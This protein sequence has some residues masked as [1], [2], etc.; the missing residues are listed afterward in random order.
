MPRPTKR[1]GSARSSAT[2]IARDA[3]IDDLPRDA[4]DA[5]EDGRDHILLDDDNRQITQPRQEEGT[6]PRSSCF[7][8]TPDPCAHSDTH[9]SLD[10]ELV[11]QEREILGVDYARDYDDDDDDDDDDEQEYGEEEEEEELYNLPEP[12]SK[13]RKKMAKPTVDVSEDSDDYDDDD[14][15]VDEDDE[16]GGKAAP[17]VD[18]LGWGSNKYAYYNANNLDNIDS[19]SEI[20]EEQARELELKEVKRLQRKSRS[21]MDD[22]DFGL[23][24]DEVEGGLGK[25]LKDAGREQRRRE[26]DG[27]DEQSAPASAAVSTE[28]EPLP[29]DEQG[30]QA[31][32]AKLQ[33]TSPETIALAGEYA[34]MLEELTKVNAG[35][36]K[37]AVEKPGHP[38][39]EVLHLHRQTLITYLTTITFYFHLRASPEYAADPAKLSSHPVLAR[40]TKLKQALSVME[41]L[42]LSF[43]GDDIDR[44]AGSDEEIDDEDGMGD[45][46][47]FQDASGD[48]DDLGSLE[49]DE[50]AA[51][52]AD[53]KENAVPAKSS[54]KNTAGGKANGVLQPVPEPGASEKKKKKS[55]KPAATQDADESGSQKRARGKKQKKA[56]PAP[57]AAGLADLDDE[58]MPE[59]K[60][61]SSKKGKAPA[62]NPFAMDQY[63]GDLEAS[64]F[65]E[66]TQLDTTDSAEKQAKK[67]SLQFHA[68]AVETKNNQRKAAR[69]RLT[70]DA[71]I[72]YRDRERSRMAVEQAK[73][74][75]RRALLGQEQDTSLDE[76]GWGESDTRDW[77]DVM[78]VDGDMDADGSGA[79]DEDGDY[80]DLIASGKRKAKKAKKDEYE[81]MRD[82][83]RFV[84]EDLLEEGQ[85][86]GINRAIEK[87]KGLAPHRPK[88]ARNPRVKKRLKYEQA[89]KRLSSRQAVFKGGQASL[90][91]GYGGESSG[92]STNLVRSRKLG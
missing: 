66:P 41:D 56:E 75:K 88:T 60:L 82:E 67:R 23:G 86:R 77:R 29:Q 81:A 8:F 7:A 45:L 79:G 13:G 70:G 91:G 52:L 54:K 10:D 78:G 84:P 53:E 43:D 65:G 49:D 2:S 47:M 58:P 76:Q 63:T 25:A 72:P 83:E 26:L 22:A 71:D 36:K 31:L 32:L 39:I 20:D 3:T 51:L 35:L 57:L 17:H 24:D 48:E 1:R 85:H 19:D 64:A 46:R 12:K 89:K 34:D 59:F 14:G 44:L 37:I 11:G 68:S 16:E 27:D 74:N 9:L 50:L 15:H 90:Q 62:S 80:Y 40:L 6:Y 4:M 73:A 33:R 28:Q 92:I 21:D 5:F 69:D 18:D 87:N 42:G 38:I 61:K 30:R 55:S